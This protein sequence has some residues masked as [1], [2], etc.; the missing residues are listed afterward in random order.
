MYTVKGVVRFYYINRLPQEFHR[1]WDNPD[2]D[3]LVT[4]RDISAPYFW[5]DTDK[6]TAHN[7]RIEWDGENAWGKVT[8]G[9]IT[10]EFSVP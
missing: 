7:M 4:N 3:F 5:D 2:T 8:Y 9:S 6:G 10:E 1:P